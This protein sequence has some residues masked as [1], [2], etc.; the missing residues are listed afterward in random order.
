MKRLLLIAG[1]VLALTS[2]ASPANAAEMPK[3]LRGVWCLDRDTGTYVPSGVCT[4]RSGFGI[5]AGG[6]IIPNDGYCAVL[7][8]R[9]L[10]KHA[11][12]S[13]FRCQDGD[14]AEPLIIDYTWRIEKDVLKV[15]A[16]EPPPLTRR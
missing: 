10:G 14:G 13:K 2:F 8:V 4:V 5:D 9:Q 7:K 6:F 12:R 16:N 3:E 11:Y 15:T 1:L